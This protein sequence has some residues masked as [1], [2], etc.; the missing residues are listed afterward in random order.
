V[1]LCKVTNGSKQKLN[2]VQKKMKTRLLF[3]PVHMGSSSRGYLV[4][5]TFGCFNFIETN[6]RLECTKKNCDVGTRVAVIVCD[7]KSHM[8]AWYTLYE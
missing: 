1:Y 2:Y 6:D 7:L 4:S 3:T 5:W 8:N